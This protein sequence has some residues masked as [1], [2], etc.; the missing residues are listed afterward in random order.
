M[1]VLIKMYFLDIGTCVLFEDVKAVPLE[2]HVSSKQFD[3]LL[4]ILNQITK[5]TALLKEKK[6]ERI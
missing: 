1:N 2:A 4:I 3:L 5:S 6:D